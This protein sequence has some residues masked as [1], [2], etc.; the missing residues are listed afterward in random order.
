VAQELQALLTAAEQQ[1]VQQ[2]STVQRPIRDSFHTAPGWR[3]VGMEISCVP[4]AVYPW[5]A[6]ELKQ[7]WAW[8]PGVVPL[9][10]RWAFLKAA[11]E[12]GGLVVF[13]RHAIG[14]HVKNPHGDMTLHNVQMPSMPC[15][16]VKFER[17]NQIELILMGETLGDVPGEFLP[18][19]P[20]LVQKLRTLY[21]ELHPKELKRELLDVPWEAAAR[22]KQQAR[23]E[24]AYRK[25][26]LDRYITRK[27]KDVSEI[28]A[29]EWFLGDLA[30]GLPTS[31]RAWSI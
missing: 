13:R 5:G 7:I 18:W 19:G 10:V 30:D 27:L 15:Q 6:A 2:V 28:E 25:R 9:W 26:D 1:K 29:R 16:G 14:R 31:K 11:D 12:G 8:D 4:D 3:D 22:R 17:P 23:A 24:D 21:R 20:W